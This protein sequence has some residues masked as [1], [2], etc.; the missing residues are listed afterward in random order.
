VFIANR[1]RGITNLAGLKG[2]TFTFGSESSTSG[3]LMPQ[4]FLGRSGIN[5]ARDFRGPAGF[6]GTHDKTLALV[7]AG[8]F[9]AGA[10]NEQVWKK[11]LEE[12]AP[13]TRQV[14]VIYTTP[15]YYDYHWVLHPDAARRLGGE[16]FVRRLSAAFLQ[17]Q[18]E[19]P[20]R[21]R[22][23]GPVRRAQVH[24]D[25]ERQLRQ[26]REDRP[27]NRPDRGRPPVAGGER[28]RRRGHPRPG[29]NTRGPTRRAA[30]AGVRSR[31][32][33]E[34]V[35]GRRWIGHCGGGGAHRRGSSD[36]TG[37]ARRP[38]RAERGG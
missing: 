26:H 17:A 9:D 23:P 14:R 19:E 20:S 22:D 3:R 25:Q 28:C 16:P 8:S 27:R 31:R 10:M 4:F 11:R 34:A 35:R 13:E 36:R 5:V 2:R 1:N 33:D 30:R 6:S 7:A 37:R 38:D 12:G 24:P 15:P 32:R 21:R 29:G 18:P